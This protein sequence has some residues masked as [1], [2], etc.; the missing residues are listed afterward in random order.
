MS[1]LVSRSDTEDGIAIIK[2]GT[3]A[4]SRGFSTEGMESISSSINS[5]L[6]DSN[7]SGIVLTGSERMFCAGADVESFKDAIANKKIVEM[8]EGLTDLLHPLLVKMRRSSKIC[9][10]AINGAAAGGGLGLA[11]ACD[12]RI[13]GQNGLLVSG[14]ASLGLSPDGG[15][16]WLLPRLVGDQI[17]RRF[18]LD[19]ERWKPEVAL[20]NGAVDEV[21]SNEE[22]IDRACQLARDWGKW[23]HHTKEATKHLL[24]VQS[25]Q[26]FESHLHHEQI[27]IM[28]ASSSEEFS[29]G[30]NAFLEKRD[31]VFK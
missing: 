23:S 27:L 20:A 13:C 22:L 28:A 21:V 3:I 26:D 18:I 15:T 14:F 17:A 30:V 7:I 25:T 9:V 16:T 4:A 11:L 24:D 8:V 5:A 19:N 1:D 12:Y 6:D 29:E 10:A 2:F 31:P